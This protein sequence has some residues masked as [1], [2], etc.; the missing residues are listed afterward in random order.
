ME[1]PT[2]GAEFNS[3]DGAV[4]DDVFDSQVVGEGA[5]ESA[6]GTNQVVPLRQFAQVPHSSLFSLHPIFALWSLVIYTVHDGL[7][8]RREGVEVFALVLAEVEFPQLR[9]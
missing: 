1:L 7:L 6:V 2:V 3:E 5:H 8:L 4:G 9:G